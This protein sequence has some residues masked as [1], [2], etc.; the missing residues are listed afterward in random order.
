MT[1]TFKIGFIE[2]VYIPL[3]VKHVRQAKQR[4]MSCNTLTKIYTDGIHAG[5]VSN[6]TYATVRL[7]QPSIWRSWKTYWLSFMLGIKKQ[8]LS[9]CK[10]ILNDNIQR[11]VGFNLP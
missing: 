11:P 2:I 4:Q 10:A 1:F 5:K 3:L 6:Y 7:W 9:N 8:Y